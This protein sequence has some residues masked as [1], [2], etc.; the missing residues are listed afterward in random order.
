MDAMMSLLALESVARLGAAVTD[1][2]RLEGGIMGHEQQADNSSID[3]TA[4]DLIASASGEL[5]EDDLE[6]VAG[7][8]SDIHIDIYIP[9]VIS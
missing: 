7:G 9:P 6:A 5:S 4:E 3:A 1:S 2:R 8:S